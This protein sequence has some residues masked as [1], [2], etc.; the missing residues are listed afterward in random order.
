M[1][2][3]LLIGVCLA[4]A[5]LPAGT[6]AARPSLLMV[7]D[8][9]AYESAG[10]LRAELPGWD[11]RHKAWPG[12]PLETGMR[13]LS[14]E[15]HPP[16]ILAFSLFTNNPA[17]EAGLLERA[18]AETLRRHPGCHIWATVYQGDP[19]GNV[20]EAANRR[21]RALERRHPDRLVVI[22]WAAWGEWAGE[23]LMPDGIH[24]TEE[25][26]LLRAQLYAHAARRCLR[27]LASDAPLR[28]DPAARG[29]LRR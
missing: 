7:G 5:A 16:R 22:D 25:G 4:L 1:A 12:V 11:V 23:K 3:K 28:L 10:L 19:L 8:S 27:R 6:G 20:H 26:K 14:Q 2:R 13:W 9:L 18:A 24:P 29:R 21:L 15:R 17:Y